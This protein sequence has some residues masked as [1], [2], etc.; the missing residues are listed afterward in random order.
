M[1][2]VIEDLWREAEYTGP[3]K[4][5][6]RHGPAQIVLTMGS[7]STMVL[8]SY[9]EKLPYYRLLRHHYSGV[10]PKLEWPSC[11]RISIPYY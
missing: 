6:I 5:G 10:L 9:I 7:I 11:F 2:E 8:S 3:I 1:V 4:L